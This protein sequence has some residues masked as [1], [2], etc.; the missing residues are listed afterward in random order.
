MSHS[1]LSG[2]YIKVLGR[3]ALTFA[4]A[5][6]T[7][8]ATAVAAGRQAHRLNE[9]RLGGQ[10]VVCAL[11]LPDA[12]RQREL[13]Y[14][15]SSTQ[16]PAHSSVQEIKKG[17]AGFMME[18]LALLLTD[19]LATG[20]GD[21]GL[22]SADLQCDVGGGNCHSLQAARSTPSGMLLALDVHSCT[23]DGSARLHSDNSNYPGPAAVWR[24][25][26][27]VTLLLLVRSFVALR[28]DLML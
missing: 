2:A 28:M 24:L 19:A 22:R 12:A 8:L 21:P 17:L 5:A 7:A 26:Q 15:W 23:V 9:G 13:L 20:A 11:A 18:T 16:S 10:G 3:L 4:D 1:A 25:G 14:E 27:F 6:A